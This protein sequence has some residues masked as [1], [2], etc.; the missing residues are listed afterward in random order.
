MWGHYKQRYLSLRSSWTT[1]V[2]I[3]ICQ[4]LAPDKQ[5]PGVCGLSKNILEVWVSVQCRESA[6]YKLGRG[7][8][9]NHNDSANSTHQDPELRVTYF[10][11]VY[12]KEILM[13]PRSFW[14]LQ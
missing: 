1:Q 5:V 14:H 2:L 12:Q 3:G 7:G 10:Y 11:Q 4:S 8:K 6:L 13:M 9:T